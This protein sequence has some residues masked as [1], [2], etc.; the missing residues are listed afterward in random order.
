MVSYRYKV[1]VRPEVGQAFCYM[2]GLEPGPYLS[3][4]L[5]EAK[6]LYPTGTVWYVRERSWFEEQ[7]REE[8]EGY[9]I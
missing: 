4:I 7:I 6:A 9:G 1:M 5:Q 3:S 2:S 8:D